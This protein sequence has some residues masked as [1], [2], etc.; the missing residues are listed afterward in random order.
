MHLG[1]EVGWYASFGFFVKLHV[2]RNLFFVRRDT[3]ITMSSAIA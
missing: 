3:R 1:R 2:N